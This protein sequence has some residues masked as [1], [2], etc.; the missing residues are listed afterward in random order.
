MR[1]VHTPRKKSNKVGFY[2]EIVAAAMTG[3]WPSLWWVEHHAGPAKLYEVET[4]DLLD[5]SSPLDALNTSKRYNGYVFV[6]YDPVCAAALRERTRGIPNMHIIEGDCNDAVVHDRIRSIVPTNALVVMYADPEDLDDLDFQTVRFF[7]ERY[8][9][10]DWLINFPVSGA[11]RYLTGDAGA[12]SRAAR[13]L[14]YPNPQRLLAE[15]TG[16]TYGPTFSAYFKRLLQSL[17]HTCMYETIYLHHPHVPFYDLFLATKD[18]TGLAMRFF[19][20]AC[21]IKANGQRTL[22]GA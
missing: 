19:E 14:D 5:G 7:T 16:R 21:D 4:R 10:L 3:K 9:H 6:E 13:L 22:F 18:T 11:V 20:K 15:C 12:G 17:G 1:V 8:R 2:V